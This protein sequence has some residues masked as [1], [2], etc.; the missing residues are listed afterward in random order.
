MDNNGQAGKNSGGR[1]VVSGRA[2]SSESFGTQ[3]R[4]SVSSGSETANY[5]GEVS[6]L[7]GSFIYDDYL[8]EFYISNYGEMPRS[9]ATVVI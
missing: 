2:G 3:G 6:P 8:K 1:D 7:V 4:T 9:W 5:R